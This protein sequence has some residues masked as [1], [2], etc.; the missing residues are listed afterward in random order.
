MYANIL[1]TSTQKTDDV[2]EKDEKAQIILVRCQV[3]KKDFEIDFNWYN[4]ETISL[5]VNT[6][7]Y[8]VINFM[9]T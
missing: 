8:F 2:L 3:W 1:G 9:L 5:I 4:Y 7:W 6:K